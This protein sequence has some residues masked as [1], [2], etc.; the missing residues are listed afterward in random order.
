M[1]IYAVPL[2]RPHG[3]KNQNGVSDFSDSAKR[4][5]TC[6][7]CRVR[8]KPE[9]W[10]APRAENVSTG[11]HAPVTKHGKAQINQ[12]TLGFSFQCFWL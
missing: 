7:E 10:P 9:T 8:E 4:G 11:K 1:N 3:G 5:K 12:V 6:N 2:Y